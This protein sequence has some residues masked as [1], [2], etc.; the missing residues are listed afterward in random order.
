[1]H[2]VAVIGG[3]PAGLTA[4]TWLGRYRRNAIVFDSG[5]YR[6]RWVDNAH[7]YLG[8]DP[9][10][11][12][13]LRA[14][15][16]EQL[17]QYRTVSVRNERVTAIAARDDG[18]FRVE[19]AD[20]T[21]PA[22]RIILAT[23]VS[24]AFPKVAGFFDHYGAD[25]F[26][27]G[28][29]DG[30]E[31]RGKDVVVFG[32]SPHVVGFAKGLLEWARSVT[33]VT[34]DHDFEGGV[35]H[36]ISLAEYGVSVIE[37]DATEL[38]GERGNLSGVILRDGGRVNCQMVFFSI[39]HNY[40]NELAISLGCEVSGEGCVLVDDECRTSVPGVFAAGDLTPG[41][42]LVQVAAAKGCIAGVSCA[43]DLS[44]L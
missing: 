42:Q 33:V 30:Y 10:V 23:G 8:F 17:S 11:P 20:V 32:W 28:T 38:V 5:E 40:M 9:M 14:R 29:C 13:E 35:G 34:D 26:H 39:A 1:M 21:S 7:G 2:D 22:R 37:D 19:T 43:R 25:V 31:A 16:R 4:A 24:D 44:E 41:M 36:K 12:G 18:T 27:C 15:A 6:N 3:G